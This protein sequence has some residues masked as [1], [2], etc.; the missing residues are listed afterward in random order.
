M[1]PSSG[2]RFIRQVKTASTKSWSSSESKTASSGA[3][4][5]IPPARNGCY[6]RSAS[7][8]RC[9]STMARSYCRGPTAGSCSKHRNGRRRMHS[10]TIQARSR[11]SAQAIYSALSDF[12]PELVGND[13]QGYT[14]GVQ[15]GN[16]D[17]DVIKLLNAIEVYVTQRQTSAS[18]DLD[19][20]RYTM[21]P[22]G[23]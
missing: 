21:H 6:S 19:G 1:S 22:D 20:H 3:N 23:N 7:T 11:D 16:V 2:Q 12:W 13:E 9:A 4:V 14:V 17:G 10:L 8:Q 18:L 5:P 15:L